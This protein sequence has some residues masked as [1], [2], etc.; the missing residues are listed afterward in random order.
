MIGN[1]VAAELESLSG[2]RL[3]L[4]QWVRKE[5]RTHQELAAEAVAI[6]QDAESADIAQYRLLNQAIPA[7]QRAENALE[8]II[9]DYQK[10]TAA[11][12]K[13][14]NRISF[15]AISIGTVLGIGMLMLVWNSISS[16]RSVSLKAIL[17]PVIMTLAVL[18]SPS[19]R[20]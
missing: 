7:S 11:N 19:A 9:D 8:S 14:I 18:S 15:F 20:D 16:G 4:F 3:E 6:R 10:A 2:T 1:Q 17:W 12:S 5:L 13:Q